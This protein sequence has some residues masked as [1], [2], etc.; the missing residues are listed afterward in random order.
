METE[1]T[2]RF[3][4]EG[5]FQAPTASGRFSRELLMAS[6]GLEMAVSAHPRASYSHMDE[7]ILPP[8]FEKVFKRP[9]SGKIR[10]SCVP[11]FTLPQSPDRGT[12]INTGW[13]DPYN[14]STSEKEVLKKSH[15]IL[16]PSKLHATALISNGF[17][18]NKIFDLPPAV[19]LKTFFPKAKSPL[20]CRPASDIFRFLWVGSPL[21][22]KGVDKLIE[23][24]IREFRPNEKVELIIKLTHMPKIKKS[25]GH[26]ISDLGKRLGSWVKDFPPVK[27]ISE[28]VADS[29]LA[30]LM[31]SADALVSS[32]NAY[33]TC[34]TVYE[35]MACG[36]PIIGPESL[37]GIS[38]LN[39]ECGYVYPT[40]SGEMPA[41]SLYPS[42]EITLCRQPDVLGL[43]MAMR[44][45]FN[46]STDAAAKG[47]KARGIAS[48]RA[49]WKQLVATLLENFGKAGTDEKPGKKNPSAGKAKPD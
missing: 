13:F 7:M 43:S 11:A 49:T 26:E 5:D 39:D 47:A 14:L 45:V 25:F 4:F 12:R 19:N 35:A 27:V 1:R 32:S 33:S 28:Y 38:G 6:R 29:D 21:R 46:C 3:C 30:A 9:P 22:R 24:Y 16:V 37:A 20:Y 36:V 17:S 15:F 8:F 31:A 44:K 2:V 42:S 23:S 40:V 48:G 34:L 41:G 10:I 18:T